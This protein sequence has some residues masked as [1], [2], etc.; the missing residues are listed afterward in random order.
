MLKKVNRLPSPRLFNSKNSSTPL[1][2]IK[3][4]SNNLKTKRFAFVISKKV[5]KRAVVRNSLRRKFSSCVEEIFDR[6][7][8]GFD[9][10]FYPSPQAVIAPREKVLDEISKILKIKND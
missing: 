1:F 5:D 2:N 9:F 7:E 6:I 3:I 8:D 4:A 10:V